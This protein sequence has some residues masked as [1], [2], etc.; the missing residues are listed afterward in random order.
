VQ[1]FSLRHSLFDI[2]HSNLS[3]QQRT[4]SLSN[5]SQLAQR[6]QR[7][8]A[9]VVAVAEVNSVGVA[10]HRLHVGDAQRLGFGGGD[11][12]QR[13]RRRRRSF[14]LFLAGGAGA[15]IAQLSDRVVAG[16]PAAPK[17]CEGV[18]RDQLKLFRLVH[19]PIIALRASG[20]V[21]LSVGGA[22]VD[23]S[24]A[25]AFKAGKRHRGSEPDIDFET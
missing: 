22:I 8:Q 18:R 17:D 23:E 7:K 12:R 2:Q 16:F 20:R 4:L 15:V 14:F 1:H 11:Y 10:A 6:F 25:L 3:N 13:H 19:S 24:L 21:Q 9:R 5:R